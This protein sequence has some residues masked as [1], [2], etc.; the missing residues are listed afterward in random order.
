MDHLVL[1]FILIPNLII[2]DAVAT[3]PQN[4]KNSIIIS[5]SKFKYFIII[6]QIK[7]ENTIIIILMGVTNNLIS[8]IFTPPYF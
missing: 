6:R 4:F 7:I 5:L 2:V 8:S 3:T 1:K